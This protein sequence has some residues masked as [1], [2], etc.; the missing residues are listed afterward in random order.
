MAV[1]SIAATDVARTGIEPTGT[2]VYS[3]YANS[4][5]CTGNPTKTD[6]VTVNNNDGA[7]SSSTENVANYEY[8]AYKISYS[9]DSNYIAASTCFLDIVP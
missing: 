6:K 9:G 5:S 3:F 8:I 1:E 4:Q 7:P 2:V